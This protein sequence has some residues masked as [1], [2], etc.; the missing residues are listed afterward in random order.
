MWSSSIKHQS[1]KLLDSMLDNHVLSCMVIIT[2]KYFI[3]HTVLS[4]ISN[5]VLHVSI[6]IHTWV[7]I[8]RGDHDNF[9][10]AVVMHLSLC[11][12]PPPDVSGALQ[13]GLT[14]NCCP[15]MGHLTIIH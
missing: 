2:W 5:L 10:F 13:G 1:T 9:R 8:V 7:T 14:Q 12:P 11:C 6:D 15:T 4:F 3:I